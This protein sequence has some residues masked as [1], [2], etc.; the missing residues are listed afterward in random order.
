MYQLGEKTLKVT[1]QLFSSNRTKLVERLRALPQLPK[2]SIVLLQG[3]KAQHRHCTD[4]EELFRQVNSPSL[5][6]LLS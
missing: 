1:M 2:T 6:Y 4:H 3:G 5:F